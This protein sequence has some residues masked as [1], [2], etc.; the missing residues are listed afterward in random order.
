MYGSGV[1]Q[2][3]SRHLLN[4]SHTA[5]GTGGKGGPRHPPSCTAN[6]PAAASVG[7]AE[8]VPAR[9]DTATEE[10]YR[11]GMTGGTGQVEVT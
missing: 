6:L 1:L 8:V 7:S 4:C 11:H 2:T 10:W 9:H 3:G 5:T